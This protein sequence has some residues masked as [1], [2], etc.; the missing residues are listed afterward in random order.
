MKKKFDRKSI[1]MLPIIL[2]AVAAAVSALYFFGIG[3]HRSGTQLGYSGH[4]SRN[5]WSAEYSRLDGTFSGKLFAKDGMQVLHVTVTTEEGSIALEIKDA[6]GEIIFSREAVLT[7]SFDIEVPPRVT[8]TVYADRHRGG[9]DI[10]YQSEKMPDLSNCGN[11]YLYGEEHSK[12]AILSEELRLWGEYYQNGARD[13][14]VELPYYT[15]E[16]LNLWMRSESDE[17]FEEVFRDWT[18]T[19]LQTQ[20][21]ASFYGEIKSK[22]PE[23]AFHGTDVGHQYDTTG[24]RYLRYL[25]ENN[26]KETEQYLLAQEAIGQGKHYYKNADAV[27]RENKLYENFIREFDRLNGADVMGI[28][29]TAHTGT[30]AMDYETGSVPCMAN[31]LKQRYGELVHSENLLLL[32]RNTIP[33][34]TG[35]MQ[36][37]GKEYEA[38]YFGKTDLSEVFPEY[39]YREFRRLENAY[40]DFKDKKKNGNVLPYDNYPMVIEEG[41]VFVIDYLKTDGTVLREFYRSDGNT[42]NGA[43]V[44]EQFIME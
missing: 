7:S 36:I 29:G 3:I 40:D 11:I 23:T 27:Y 33:L 34:E 1:I 41:Q 43:P 28:Y 5:A 38:S 15:A 8:V 21:V 2:V 18:G 35:K 31:R 16:F 32:A 10:S 4:K 26:Q 6:K 20:E 24:E 22:Y 30:E 17:I 14:F 37:D 39:Q 42:W 13:L 25:R 44:T 19:A 9:F 12:E